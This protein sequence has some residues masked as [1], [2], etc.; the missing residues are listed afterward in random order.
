MSGRPAEPAGRPCHNRSPQR[1]D[2]SGSRG[3][4]WIE[5]IYRPA[6]GRCDISERSAQIA[7]GGGASG[8]C[9]KAKQSDMSSAALSRALRGLRPNV[10]SQNLTRLTCECWTCE[11]CAALAYG[12]NT[13]HPT[14]D[15]YRNCVPSVHFS[16]SGGVTWSYQPPQSSQV[17]KMT[18]FGQRPPLTTASTWS[19][20]HFWPALTGSTGCSLSPVGP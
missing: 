17:M 10:D 2:R 14:R 4:S 18:V 6:A 19:A 12:L 3:V 16:T 13:R 1:P 15:P 11:T 20:V 7:G 5:E 8:F 9:V